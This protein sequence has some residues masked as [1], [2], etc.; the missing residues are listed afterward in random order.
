MLKLFKLLIELLKLLT[1]SKTFMK[2][3]KLLTP[4]KTF[5]KVLKLLKLLM[6][7]KTFSKMLTPLKTLSKVSIVLKTRFSTACAYGNAR[8]PPPPLPSAFIKPR[9]KI[10]YPYRRTD[11]GIIYL[12]DFLKNPPSAI[13]TYFNRTSTL[14][15]LFSKC[16]PFSGC[17]GD[18][19]TCGSFSVE[20]LYPLPPV[21]YSSH[22]CASMYATSRSTYPS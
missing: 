19:S 12:R 11:R 17:S 4:S 5:M 10:K 15:W 9:R 2:V 1:L 14:T 21:A 6:L 20:S 22:A 18:T 8:T 3:L 16:Q 7:L 13:T